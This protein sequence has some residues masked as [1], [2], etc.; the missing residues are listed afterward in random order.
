MNREEEKIVNKFPIPARLAKRKNNTLVRAM[1]AM[2]LSGKSLNQVAVTYRR[3]CSTILDLFRNRGF[4][5]RPIQFKK[6]QILDGI[7]F[8]EKCDGYYAAQP[9]RKKSAVFMHRYVWEKA[10]GPLPAGF[11]ITH[12]NG[13][14]SDNGIENLVSKPKTLIAAATLR[15][16]NSYK[17]IRVPGYIAAKKKKERADRWERAM[18]IG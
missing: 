14:R 1:Y 13:D 11:A 7:R 18:A 3:S 12:L 10:H 15:K 16:N 4:K 8:H 5:T 9:N 2:Y 6:V 17:H